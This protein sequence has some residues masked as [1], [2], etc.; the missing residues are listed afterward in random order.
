MSI[1]SPGSPWERFTTKPVQRIGC[2][3]KNRGFR[4][5]IKCD[6]Y[7]S[8]RMFVHRETATLPAIRDSVH[9]LPRGVDINICHVG[10]MLMYF[11]TEGTNAHTPHPFKYS[12]SM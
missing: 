2:I 1:P 6:H 12:K 3:P 8:G 10:D 11:L 4:V 9:A 5:L 7:I